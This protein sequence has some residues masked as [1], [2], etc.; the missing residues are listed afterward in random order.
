MI[1]NQ[2]RQSGKN[3][4]REKSFSSKVDKNKNSI[5]SKCFLIHRKNYI[6]HIKL[7]CGDVL[8]RY[9]IYRVLMYFTYGMGFF[10]NAE[11]AAR[12]TIWIQN[13]DRANISKMK[14]SLLVYRLG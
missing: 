2:L 13:L 8:M 10:W 6:G 7:Y 5:A 1:L 3:I 9:K 14:S 11:N 4:G 12:Q